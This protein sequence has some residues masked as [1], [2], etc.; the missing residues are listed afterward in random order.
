VSRPIPARTIGGFGPPPRRVA[1]TAPARKVTAALA[2]LAA[3]A[4]CTGGAP[5]APAGRADGGGWPVEVSSTAV[6]LA[7]RDGYLYAVTTPGERF[8]SLV[9]RFDAAGRQVARQTVGGMPSGL[10][11]APDGT[12]WLSSVNHPDVPG[13]PAVELLD[14]ARVTVRHQI[15]PGGAPGGIGYLRNEAWVATSRGLLVLDATTGARRRAAAVSA[16]AFG[17]L[18][19]PDWAAVV[20][21]E[22]GALE[23]VHAGTGRPIA[24][25]PIEAGGGL[26]AVAAGTGAWVGWPGTDGSTSLRRFAVPGLRPGPFGPR[27]G[28]RGVALAATDAALWVA[29][30]ESGRLLCLD[31]ATGAVRSSRDVPN[32]GAL[33]A[34][35]TYVYVADGGRIARVG[36][37]CG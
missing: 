6:G 28:D 4:G 2:V 1:P 36:A 17:V 18:A 25:R 15:D 27:L 22:D 32:E 34:D 16:R 31:P 35:D 29:D 26:T 13:R 23:S 20:A 37:D 7:A 21:V 5:A 19:R 11:V 8:P 9:Y 14:P 33:A 12:P 3:V 10:A 30:R 24:R